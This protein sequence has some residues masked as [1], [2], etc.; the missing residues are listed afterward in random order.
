ML[1]SLKKLLIPLVILAAAV[2]LLDIGCPIRRLTGIPC[3][4]CGMTRACL[5][6][7]RL[8]FA[9]A[10]RLHPLWFLPVPLF[11]VSLL[12]TPLFKDKRLENTFWIGMTVLVIGVYLV[13][14]ILYFPHTSP[15]EYDTGAVLYRLW[16][17]LSG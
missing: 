14:M 6:A 17:I 1:R 2:L 10:F 8:D 15:M 7:L 12:R 16:K 4:G 5:A 9:E 3:P 13:R 11:A